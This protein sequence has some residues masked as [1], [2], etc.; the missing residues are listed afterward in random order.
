MTQATY[1]Q[2]PTRAQLGQG[3]YSL[4]DLRTYLS[5]YADDVATGGFA[6]N[7]LSA[8]LN[9]AHGHVARRPDYAFS[10]LISLFVVRELRRQGVRQAKIRQ[11]EQHLRQTT[12][13]ERPFVHREVMTDGRDVWIAGDEP[14]QVEAASGPQGQQ[15]SRVALSAYLT[16]VQ[17]TDNV[18][19]TWKPAEHVLLS[20]QLQFGEPVVAGTRVATA[21]VAEIAEIAGA[22]RAAAR[23]GIGQAQANAAISFEHRLTAF[24]N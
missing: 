7:W 19:A 16:A 18:A 9:P 10:D 8:A 17:Y 4:D 2:Q 21:A 5:Y 23:L 24:R 22:E 14:D 20:P 12:G 6:L 3:I 1:E 15:A 11:A 13:L